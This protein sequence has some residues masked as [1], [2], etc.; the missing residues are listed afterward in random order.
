MTLVLS[1]CLLHITHALQA[2]FTTV[3]RETFYN[4]CSSHWSDNGNAGFL[5]G[6]SPAAPKQL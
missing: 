1:L 6:H 3:L 4:A 2:H 5:G